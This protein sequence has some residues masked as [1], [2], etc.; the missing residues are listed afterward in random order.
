LGIVPIF[1]KDEEQ[2]D[3]QRAILLLTRLQGK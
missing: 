1:W 3:G 2:E